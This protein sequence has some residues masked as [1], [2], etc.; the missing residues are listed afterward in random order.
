MTTQSP[1]GRE[2]TNLQH[3]EMLYIIP[4]KYTVEELPAIQNK[5]KGL[6][7]EHGCEITYEEDLGKRKLAYAIK[8][9][10][11]G[12]YWVIEFNMAP[13]ELKKLNNSLRLTSEV[14]RHLI[15]VKRQKTQ[16]EMAAEKERRERAEV[17][18]VEELKEKI[19]AQTP[20]VAEKE[21]EK[22]VDS[23]K[24][25]VSIEDLDKKLDELIDDSIL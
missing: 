7:A 5:I 18:E 13:A 21:E 23:P 15:I 16:A 4:V 9:V 22:K 24:G 25:K 12:Y 14:L 8:Q 17:E 6:L 3:Y 1:A 19:A 11:H 20:V 10:Y 2:E